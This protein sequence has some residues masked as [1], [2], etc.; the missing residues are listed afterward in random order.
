MTTEQYII[1]RKLSIIELGKSLKNVSAACRHLNVSRQHHYD[2]KNRVAEE[3]LEGLIVKSRNSPRLALRTPQP[4]EDRILAHSLD[5]PSHGN[6]RVASELASTGIRIS[7]GGVRCVWIRHGLASKQ[8]RLK[9][10]EAWAAREGTVLSAEQQA[11]LEMIK[12][13]KEAH[14]EIETHHPGFL[15]GQD[16][17]YVGYIKG[18]GSIYQ[19]T[20]I[21]TYSNY[22]FAKLY[23]DKTAL[24]AADVL[25]S[26]VLPF[27]DSHGLSILR[28]LT[29]NGPE[30]CGRKGHHPYELFLQLNGIEHSRTRP[31]RPQSNGITEKL[32]QN[33]QNEFYAVEFRRTTHS[34]LESLQQALDAFMERYNTLRPS[35][36]KHCKGR[37]PE[38]TFLDGI[39]LY[40]KLVHKEDELH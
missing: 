21:D 38:K 1:Q 13:R 40:R 27:F 5:F 37:T 30:Y 34:S 28:T 18:V 2:L 19:Q 15:V 23:G 16:T 6:R 20:V 35:Q 32:N 14:G 33:I 29:D 17:Y 22:G 8:A 36:G 31:Y 3:G 7:G 26:K 25:N 11:S 4:I 12:Q 9:R 10:L 39:E 24:P